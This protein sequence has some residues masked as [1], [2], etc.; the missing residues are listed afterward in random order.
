M[1]IGGCSFPAYAYALRTLAVTM[2]LGFVGLLASA[3]SGN[4]AVGFLVSFCWYCVLQVESLGVIFRSVS[5]G[6][7]AYQVLLLLGSGAAIVFFSARWL[8]RS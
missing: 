8:Q 7:S 4:T 3:V 1:S 6:I 2:T 5:N